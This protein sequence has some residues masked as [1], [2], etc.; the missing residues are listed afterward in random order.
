MADALRAASL[1]G[2]ILAGTA[3]PVRVAAQ[4]P[5]GQGEGWAKLSFFSHETSERFDAKG[6]ER[7][8]FTGGES[9]SRAL[10]LD[11][12]VGVTDYLDVWLQAPWFDL[13]F[14][15]VGGNRTASGPSDVRAFVRYGLGR[16]LLGGIPLSVRGGVKIPVQDLPVDAEIIPLGEGQW[17][18][19]AWLEG[20][21]SFYP[22]PLYAVGWL[23]YR[24]RFENESVQ[25][26]PGDERLFLLDVGL[27]TR[28]VG[29]KVVVEGLYGLA[30]VLQGILVEQGR[31]ESLQ[32]QPEV[33]VAL[34]STLYL[35]G[36]VRLPVEGR[37]HPAGRQYVAALFYQ[38]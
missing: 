25:R 12:L 13:A 1:V 35:Q 4:W 2:L 23:G 27:T 15:D 21:H 34:G 32:V 33:V 38:F 29:F 19:E 7:L 16:H 37:N 28:P 20:G 31:R 10:Y 8:F 6:E 9:V 26:D 36:G 22:L 17:D 18:V 11:A 30:P 14:D 3:M 5:A 24:W